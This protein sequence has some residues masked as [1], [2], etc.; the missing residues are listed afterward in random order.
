MQ[1]YKKIKH[2]Q[3]KDKNI[4]LNHIKKDVQTDKKQKN[5]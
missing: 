2:Q 5:N 3:K 4:L 1:K